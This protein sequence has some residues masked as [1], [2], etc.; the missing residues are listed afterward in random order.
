MKN[1]ISFNTKIDG[2]DVKLAVIKPTARDNDEADKSYGRKY[3]DLVQAGTMIRAQAEKIVKDRELWGEKEQKEL[4]E[5]RDRLLN[6][7]RKLQKGGMKKSE[8]YAL[9]MEMIKDR[10]Q[11][12]SLTLMRNPLDGE[13]AESKAEN[14]KF[15]CL[16]SMCTVYDNDKKAVFDNVNDFLSKIEEPYA[17]EAANH[18][19]RLSNDLS[20]FKSSLPE[21]KFLLK[22]GYV[23][24]KYQLIDKTGKLVDEK[25]RYVDE[26]GRL[27]R[28]KDAAC[29]EFEY[30]DV[31]GNL[32]DENGNYLGES[33]P[34]TDDDEVK[35]V[36]AAS[37]LV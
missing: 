25:G 20:D 13:T 35:A 34:F 3:R 24:E 37:S 5:V 21:Y 18:F 16:V 8:G 36:S 14:Y 32:V 9:A 29:K 7:E 1:K 12:F 15:Y 26:R 31:E 10:N 6:N 2:E 33:A 4:N 17:I 27:I 22:Y 11:L 30:V 23:N 28:Y 19:S